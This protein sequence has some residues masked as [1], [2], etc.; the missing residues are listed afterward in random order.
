M[1]GLWGLVLIT[2][3]WSSGIYSRYVSIVDEAQKTSDYRQAA[4]QLQ[5]VINADPKLSLYSMQQ[6][7]LYGMAASA[8]DAEAAR[9][10]VAAYEN[11]IVLDPGYAVVWAN[12]AALR[13]QLGERELAVEA[14]QQ[15]AKLDSVNWQYP[16]N[17]GRYAEAMGDAITA[18]STYRR[19]LT[20]YP[21]SGLYTELRSFVTANPDAL[22]RL[23]MTIPAQT[24]LLLESG[25]VEAASQLWVQNLQPESV[26]NTVMQSVLLVNDLAAAATWLSKA[27]KLATQASDQ[28]WV[29]VGRARLARSLGDTALADEEMRLAR[30]ALIREPL[31]ADDV[32]LI[33]IAYAQFLQFAIPR[34]FLPQVYYPVDDPILIYLLEN[35]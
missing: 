19:A 22:D 29:H 30:E 15:A 18:N 34:Q 1:V 27:E 16:V 6:A 14:M 4:E 32:I 5:S 21:D 20:L 23:R 26:S 2:G 25:E 9:A 8:G 10:G 11:F 31:E 35:T 24:T 7:F 33:N 12:L 3:F 17:L 28:A 13:W